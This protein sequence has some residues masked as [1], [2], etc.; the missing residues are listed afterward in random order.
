MT[1]SHLKLTLNA[2]GNLFSDGDARRLTDYYECPLPVYVKDKFVLFQCR[3]RITEALAVFMRQAANRGIRRIEPELVR[4]ED[5]TAHRS[6]F[7]T[8]WNHVLDDG[9]CA[10][11]NIIRYVGRR[12]MLDGQMRIELVE[13]LQAEEESLPLQL[14]EVA[15]A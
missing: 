1:G 4:I 7:V 9:S 10:Y 15:G 13:Y 8:R 11:C 14:L 6:L 2:I 3:D 5:A 12:G